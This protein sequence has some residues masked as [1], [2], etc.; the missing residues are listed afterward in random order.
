MTTQ[1]QSSIRPPHA[2]VFSVSVNDRPLQLDDPK[3]AARQVLVAAGF[4][5]AD[6]CVLI[7]V[8]RDSTR[9][10]ALDETI[11]LRGPD[12]EVFWA[13]K[14]DRVFRFTLDGRGFEWGAALIAEPSV[15]SIAHVDENKILVLERKDQPDQEL[16]PNDEV[17]LCEAGT[18]HLR[19]EKR[20]LEVFFQDKPYELPRGTYTTQQLMAKFPIEEG[21]LLNLKTP[22]GD[23]VTLTPGQQ[24]VL[25]CGMRF[26]SQ[27]PGGGSS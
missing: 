27:V 19:T 26:Y 12:K 6:E 23:L 24:V 3:P 13:F 15:R 5:P 17:R 21:Y 8:L 16:G 9:S 7:Q 22:E 18:E 4:N 11:D 2:G 10:V 14:M 1:T 20:L 25:K